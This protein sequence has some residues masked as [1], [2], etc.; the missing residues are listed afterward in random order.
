MGGQLACL[1]LLVGL[2]LDEVSMAA[3]AIAPVKAAIASLEAS[4][5]THVLS[6]ALAC[7]TADEVREI[8]ARFDAARPVP[9]LDTELI[10]LDGEARTKEEAIKEAVDALYVAG[11]SDR[12][13]EVE[14][15]VWRR[16][17]QYST[18]FGH[19]FAIPH[20]RTD[21]VRANSMVLVKLRAP[22]DW[23]AL[24]EKPVDVLLLLVIRESDRATEHL[25]VLAALARKLMHEEFREQVSRERDR[26]ALCRLLADTVGT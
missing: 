10:L 21:A 8:L 7:S 20:C 13:N 22:V 15:A 19:G 24:D 17:A 9:L 5:C 14:E 12:P 11:R 6:D 18:G 23:G 3:P 1:P 16:E 26:A 2:G 25:K 4:A